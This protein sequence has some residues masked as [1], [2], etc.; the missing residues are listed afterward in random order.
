MEKNNIKSHSSCYL[1]NFLEKKDPEISSIIFQ[2]RNRQEYSIELIASENVASA[3]V[4]EAAGSILT[5]KYAEGYSGKR[6]YGGCEFIDKIEDLAIERVKKLFG[7]KY[8]NVQPH[9]GSQ[10]NQTVFMATLQ[11][12]DKI[13]SMSLNCGGHLTHGHIANQSGK[14]FKVK[15]YGVDDNGL[16]NF[17]EVQKLA[18]EFKPKMII[19]GASAYSRKI[20]FVHF[21]EIANSVNAYLLADIAHYAGLIV[22]ENYPNPMPHAHFVT[23]TTHKTLRGPRGGIILTNDQDLAK[24][25]DTAL[26]PGIQGGPLMH[27]IA[28]KAV[29]FYEA[30]QPN[31]KKYIDNVVQ[32]AK[33]MS[34][35]IQK[36]GYKIVSHGTDS[37]L[38]IVNLQNTEITGLLAEKVL[39]IFGITCN[40][41]SVPHD[42]AGPTITSGLRIGSPT[43]ISRKFDLQSIEIVS[44]MICDVLDLCQN[45]IKVV[46]SKSNNI[47]SSSER[48]TKSE[49]EI[50]L[51]IIKNHS[52]WEE[53]FIPIRSKVIDLCKKFPLDNRIYDE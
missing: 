2:E 48:L 24:K 17:D 50:Q 35:I 13:L 43:M 52:L 33:K 6:Y 26:F 39:D 36:R 25:I 20:D 45:I 42:R 47:F 4:M 15:H 29:A 23:S 5:N 22:T 21:R 1:N 46:I 10:A 12:G 38:M 7:A 44:H 3:A 14:W 51:E 8:A 27:I 9:S 30:M 28:A 41:N 16:I 53:K 11:P 32:A 34:E 19:A 37:H 18:L 31:F 40:K 49:I